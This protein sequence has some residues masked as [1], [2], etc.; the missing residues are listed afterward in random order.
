MAKIHHKITASLFY[1]V[2][3]GFIGEWLRALASGQF[4]DYY[5]HEKTVFWIVTIL[6]IPLLI[7]LLYLWKLRAVD[8]PIR[9]RNF[10]ANGW[11]RLLL[12]IPINTRVSFYL[13]ATVYIAGAVAFGIFG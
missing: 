7:R 5:Q 9:I 6:N 8:E 4:A 3:G 13:Y 2:G 1:F 10:T 11:S 12:D